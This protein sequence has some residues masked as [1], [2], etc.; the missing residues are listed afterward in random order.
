MYSA[1][2]PLKMLGVLMGSQSTER[3]KPYEYPQC[4]MAITSQ[5]LCDLKSNT[6]FQSFK[7]FKYHN[8]ND[9]AED[10]RRVS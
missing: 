6:H 9:G 5:R 8:L 1:L 2:C 7:A 3:A 10:G 4:E